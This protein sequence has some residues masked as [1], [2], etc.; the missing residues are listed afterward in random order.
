MKVSVYLRTREIL[1]SSY[2][3]IGQY[4]ER[5]DGIEYK[6]RTF[7]K[8][9]MYVTNRKL[10]N[11]PIISIISKI[12]VN[13]IG[14]YNRIK[15][16]FSDMFIFKPD[17]IIIQKMLFPKFATKLEMKIFSK[18][19]NKSKI[20]W[21]FD[22]N[23]KYSG[24]ISELEF[25]NLEK[26]SSHII[27][28]HKGLKVTVKPEFQN[29][30]KLLPTT[31]ILC[32]DF[33]YNN[34][35]LNRLKSYNDEINLIWLGTSSNFPNLKNILK[36]IDETAELLKTESGKKIRLLNVSDK[37]LEYTPK[38][39]EIINVSWN[40]KIASEMLETAHIG[41]MPLNNNKYNEGKGAFKA[42][43][44]IGFGLPTIVS[45]VGFSSDVIENNHNGFV[46]DNYSEW[47]EGLLKL[48]QDKELWMNMSNNSQLKWKNEFNA[49]QIIEFLTCIIKN[50]DKLKFR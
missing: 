18:M 8:D 36:V 5:I 27:T 7:L 45:N 26:L 37:V 24:E 14:H 32:L 21:D 15:S 16:I 38:N 20:I 19:S 46:Y 41:L 22:D 42:V 13:T 34:I 43:Q 4:L 33:D 47:K 39:Y 25:N 35:T 11:I 2:Y 10:S 6:I 17:V 1:P 12:I 23:I 31:D 30:V 9:D 28:T 29:K 48:C 40:R 3:R 50:N 49:A 44:Y